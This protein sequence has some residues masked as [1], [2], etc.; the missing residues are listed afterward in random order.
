MTGQRRFGGDHLT[1]ADQD[2]TQSPL[3]Q[4]GA[5]QEVQESPQMG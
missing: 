4:L 2:G 5:G 3:G 1:V